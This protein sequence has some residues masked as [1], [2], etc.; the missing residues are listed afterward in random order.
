VQR[1]LSPLTRETRRDDGEVVRE[2]D[3]VSAATVLAAFIGAL[4]LIFFLAS[5][6]PWLLSKGMTAAV[7]GLMNRIGFGDFSAD[8]IW[9]WLL[10]LLV[11]AVFTAFLVA[12]ATSILA[13]YNVL[14]QRTGM[15]MQVYPEVETTK[16][17]AIAEPVE[18][19][20][21][22]DATFDE[23]YAEAQRKSIKGRSHMSKGELRAA[24]RRRSRRGSSKRSTASSRRR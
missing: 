10:V 15:G 9:S 16:R 23:L 14:S 8:T 5:F 12:I 21:Y 13:L 24:L 6:L 11:F 2:F 3:V 18:E 22:D 17:A 1:A 7:E 20:E 4:F 19:D